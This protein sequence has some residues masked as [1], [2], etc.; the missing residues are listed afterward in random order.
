MCK[1]LTDLISAQKNLKTFDIKQVEVDE[2]EDE[3]PSLITALPNTLIK[4]NISGENNISLSLITKLTDLQELKLFFNH[5]EDF[6]DF[7]ELQYVVFP[8]LQ[9][10]KIERACPGYELLIKFLENNGKNL[11]E[12]YIGDIEG[13]SDNSLNLAIAKFCPNL[14]K[15][16]AGFKNNESETL[17]IVFKSCQYLESFNIWCGGEFL[18]E[19]ETLEVIAKYS[20]KNIYELILNY[21]DYTGPKLLPEE[22]EDF[23]ISWKNRISQG[24][25]SLVVINYDTNSSDINDKNLEI[26]DKYIKLGVIKRFTTY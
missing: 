19:K 12:L 23:F 9:I 14:R 22:L 3:I 10:L 26:I 16:S 5:N 6:R 4:L 25:L 8:R 11:K 7:E 21:L 20:H 17:K 13:Y 18:S 2:L 24:S 15:L 1:G